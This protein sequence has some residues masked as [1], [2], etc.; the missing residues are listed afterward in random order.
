[1]T[2][3]TFVSRLTG[4]PGRQV[5]FAKTKDVNQGLKIAL[6]VQEAEMQESFNESFYTQFDKS[7]RLCSRPPCRSRSG[8]DSQRQTANSRTLNRPLAQRYN[9]P[10][11][12]SR[13]EIPSA[14][15]KQTEA[16]LRCN[17]CHGVGNFA[18]ECQTRLKGRTK[19][20]GP[21]GGESPTELSKRSRPTN[22]K[23]PRESAQATR[24][25]AK[26]SGNGDEA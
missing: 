10:S 1:M 25:E 7:V 12:A 5:R 19:F 2:L 3:T 16:A 9:T 21:P 4:V 11:G 18:K 17:E 13:S 6:T 8:S 20:S 23:S 22:G 15:N 14:R 26:D 24:W